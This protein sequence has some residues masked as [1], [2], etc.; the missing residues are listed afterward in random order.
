MID[1]GYCVGLERIEKQDL[2]QLRR[3]RNNYQVWKW[4]RQ[5]DELHDMAHE[6]WFEK[7]A[8][9]PKISMYKIVTAAGGMV[10]VC[11]LT[12][13]DH[14]NRRAEF[15]L[16]IGPEHQG[17][18]HAK[19]ALQTLFQHGFDNLNLNLIWGE[20]FAGNPAEKLFHK[21]GMR[22]EGVR[23]QHYYRAGWY[24]DAILYSLLASEFK[25]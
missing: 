19:H 2:P 13:I 9:D 16:Y 21:L 7:Q 4:C 10:G 1:Y 8:S 14:I 22:K 17:K 6:Q 12:D 11:G 20:T 23:R 25:K 3:W 5:N 24:V 18:G 15:S